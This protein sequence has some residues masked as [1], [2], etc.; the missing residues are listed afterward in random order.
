MIYHVMQ[1]ASWK[2]RE[3]NVEGRE[4]SGRFLSKERITNCTL[5][6]VQSCRKVCNDSALAM[7][8]KRFQFLQIY[9]KEKRWVQSWPRRETTSGNTLNKK[10]VN[11]NRVKTMDVD[12]VTIKKNC[13]QILKLSKFQSLSCDKTRFNLLTNFWKRSPI[14]E[15]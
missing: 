2:I 15:N 9:R 8:A 11:F 12:V 1:Q 5:A 3:N 7:Y 14:V 6:K 13:L 4:E 10:T